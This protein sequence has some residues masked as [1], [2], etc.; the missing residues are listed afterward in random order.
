MIF[1]KCFNY[2]ILFLNY[3]QCYLEDIVG[4]VNVKLVIA[5]C[6]FILPTINLFDVEYVKPPNV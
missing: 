2:L 3:E 4:I 5:N 6:Y 1:T